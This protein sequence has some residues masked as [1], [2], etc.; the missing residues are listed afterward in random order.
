MT[1]TREQRTL[2]KTRSHLAALVVCMISITPV[3]YDGVAAQTHDCGDRED[4]VE[5]LN[6]EL[7]EYFAAVEST[8]SGLAYELFTSVDG[9]WTVILSFPD[10]RS[11][12]VASGAAENLSAPDAAQEL[13]T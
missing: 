8:E 12:M 9:G 2:G 7:E 5:L 11:C 10:G 1:Q 4:I 3:S 13:D 6:G